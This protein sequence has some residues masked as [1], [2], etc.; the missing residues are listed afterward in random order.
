MTVG[1]D[2]SVVTDDQLDNYAL[3]LAGRLN[4]ILEMFRTVPGMEYEQKKPRKRHARGMRCYMCHG[5]VRNHD[6]FKRC[7]G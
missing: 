3:M 2:T 1:E 4:L 6:P 7:S 5:L